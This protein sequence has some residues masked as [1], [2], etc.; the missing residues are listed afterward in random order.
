MAHMM[1]EKMRGGKVCLGDRRRFLDN[2]SA[3][4]GWPTTVV[5]IQPTVQ[6]L[7]LPESSCCSP[8]SP[9]F[10]YVI[11]TLR[12]PSINQ[13]QFHV[14]LK[15]LSKDTNNSHSFTESESQLL[16]MTYRVLLSNFLRIK[17]KPTDEQ[18]RSSWGLV[19]NAGSQ[20]PLQAT[21]TDHARHQDPQAT[22]IHIHI[23]KPPCLAPAFLAFSSGSRPVP[24]TYEMLNKCLFRKPNCQIRQPL[25]NPHLI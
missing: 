22:E 6:P 23:R 15:V 4:Y 19:R 10:Q 2:P 24:G 21:A 7:E 1:F 14:P 8:N 5:H 13:L 18:C 12:P 25:F 16:T 11:S 9:S 17:V 3:C 20:A